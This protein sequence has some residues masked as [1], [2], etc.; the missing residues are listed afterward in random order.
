MV[1]VAVAVITRRL[2]LNKHVA[3]RLDGDEC[4]H[5]IHRCG[6]RSDRRVAIR[7]SVL[8]EIVE[9]GDGH[10][11]QRCTLAVPD[12]PRDGAFLRIFHEVVVEVRFRRREDYRDVIIRALRTVV[13]VRIVRTRALVVIAHAVVARRMHLYDHVDA[14][15]HVFKT[16]QA[17]FAVGDGCRHLHAIG[18]TAVPIRIAPELERNV[19]QRITLVVG[20]CSADE[21]R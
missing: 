14:V 16:I 2:G 21:A 13:T 5:A 4:E 19:G 8:V 10:T 15:G 1:V 20:H 11:S 12:L 6:R 18:C 17:R 9:Q 7:Q 3:R